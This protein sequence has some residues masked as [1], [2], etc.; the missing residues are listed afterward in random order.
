MNRGR[1]GLGFGSRAF[2]FRMSGKKHLYKEVSLTFSLFLFFYYSQ[3]PDSSDLL[4][5]FSQKLSIQR[6]VKMQLPFQ[7]PILSSLF[8]SNLISPKVECDYFITRPISFHSRSSDLVLYAKLSESKVK[9]L[10]GSHSSTFLT[11]LNEDGSKIDSSSRFDF[12]RCDSNYIG[13]QTI[14]SKYNSE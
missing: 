11:T 12:Y 14:R 5:I 1:R 7:L 10:D 2:W 8:L 6:V 13:Y 3:S 9:D 4:L